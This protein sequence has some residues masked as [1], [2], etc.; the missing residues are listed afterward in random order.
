VLTHPSPRNRGWFT[1][2]PWFETDT[3]PAVR[4]RVDEILNDA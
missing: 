2:N 3:L 1:K 4:G